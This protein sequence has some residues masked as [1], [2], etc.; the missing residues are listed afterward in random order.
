MLDESTSGMNVSTMNLISAIKSKEETKDETKGN[1]SK[2][3]EA[4][5]LAEM[6]FDVEDF[7][8]AQ[9]V[10]KGA[11][12]EFKAKFKKIKKGLA[13]V[14]KDKKPAKKNIGPAQDKLFNPTIP[15][16]K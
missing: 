9:N 16:R 15:L 3:V 5:T 6:E 7:R 11:F 10:E 1:N 4:K 12:E 13:T 14:M 8:I 2:Y